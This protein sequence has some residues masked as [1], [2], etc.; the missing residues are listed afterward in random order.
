MTC[1]LFQYVTHVQ[2]F[3][4]WHICW[5]FGVLLSTLLQEGRPGERPL[6]R[7]NG[8]KER[9]KTVLSKGLLSSGVRSGVR[10]A[11][12]ELRGVDG[13]GDH[14]KE[15]TVVLILQEFEVNREVVHW[16]KHLVHIRD[17]P[18]CPVGLRF[19][20]AFA[21][22]GA[23]VQRGPKGALDALVL[24]GR[25]DFVQEQ[26]PGVVSLHLDELPVRGLA[27]SHREIEDELQPSSSFVVL[28]GFDLV[29]NHGVTPSDAERPGPLTIAVHMVLVIATV[30]FEGPEH[31]YVLFRQIS[32]Q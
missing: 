1:K 21:H 6:V 30:Y 25:K 18:A 3:Q 19:D 23:V 4:Y 9:G 17:L 10:R 29:G 31:P 14:L 2:G 8:D 13:L 24:H 27:S 12:G 15:P 7:T 11:A 5:L 32:E 22:G 28:N 20:G 16:R 26:L